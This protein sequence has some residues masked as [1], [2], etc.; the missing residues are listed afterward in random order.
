MRRFLPELVA[1]PMLPVL[2]AQ[3]RHARRVTPRLPAAGGPAEG[4]AGARR[5][6]TPL[7]LIAVGE[8][9]VAGVGVR[10]HEEAIT[11]QFARAL[12]AGADRPVKW[13]ACGRNGVTVREALEVLVPCIPEE[14]VDVA[15]IAFGINDT[16]AFRP[17]RRWREDYRALLQAVETRCRPRVILVSGIPPIGHFPA[18]PQPLRW[19]M[20]L[21]AEALDHVVRDLAAAHPR[22]RHVALLFDVTDPALMAEDGYHPS[23]KGCTAWARLL[24]AASGDA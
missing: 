15:L 13:R 2:I 11:G 23:A 16:T 22:A 20:G 4:T 19:V 8:S 6:G 17:L 5:P 12:S 1:L 10:M 18:L 24:A 21:K 9:P 7:S 14:P 3:G